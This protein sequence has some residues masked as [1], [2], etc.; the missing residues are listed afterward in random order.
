MTDCQDSMLK[1][2]Y[3]STVCEAADLAGVIFN[4]ALIHKPFIQLAGCLLLL[5]FAGGVVPQLH[6]IPA[7]LPTVQHVH[8]VTLKVQHDKGGGGPL[9]SRSP[10][11]HHELSIIQLIVVPVFHLQTV[12]CM[13]P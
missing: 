13:K 3:G 8:N 2:D 1:G 5:P 6:N 9:A 4:V 7:E 12:L 10:D 11:G